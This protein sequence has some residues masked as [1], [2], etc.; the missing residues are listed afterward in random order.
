MSRPDQLREYM[1]HRRAAERAAHRLAWAR[2]PADAD[3]AAAE[4]LRHLRAALGSA[5]AVNRAAPA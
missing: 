3:A 4:A 1:A 5:W 2:T